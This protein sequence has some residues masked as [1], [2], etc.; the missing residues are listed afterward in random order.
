MVALAKAVFREGTVKQGGNAAYVALDDSQ[1][2]F[3][4]AYQAEQ[5]HFNIE[6]GH[7]K[8]NYNYNFNYNFNFNLNFNRHF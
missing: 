8:S 6:N 4:V 3:F 5:S 2:R 1:G 7:F